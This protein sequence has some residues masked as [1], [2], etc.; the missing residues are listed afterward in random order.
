MHVLNRIVQHFGFV[1]TRVAE[2]PL[3]G[4]KAQVFRDQLAAAR[5]NRRGIPVR[6]VKL[7]DDS[8]HHPHE[9]EDSQCAFASENLRAI[10]PNRIL[11]IGSMRHWSLGLLAHHS[12]T[13]LDVRP[14]QISV[15]GETVVTEDAR[16]LSFADESF[17]LVVSL[18][19][20]AHIG[21]GRYGD[22]FDL[23]GD[24]TALRE[25]KRVIA[26][27]GHLLLTLPLSL[28]GPFIY[29]NT[30]RYYDRESI[31]ELMG[32]MSIVD[33]KVYSHY[34]RAVVPF[35]DLSVRDC[36]PIYEQYNVYCGCWKK[37][38]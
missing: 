13:S 17:D 5:G 6:G 7:Q 33:E 19:T 15:S 30:R 20:L 8:G 12:I 9:L 18:Y 26:K 16:K 36:D 24:L 21:L 34:H 10:R 1:V 3:R 29:F 22:P 37:P 32:D 2:D 31:R 25:M 35:E 27:G 4:P 38:E 23:D 28:G 14:R 11:D